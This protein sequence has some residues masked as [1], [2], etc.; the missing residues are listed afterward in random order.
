MHRA[1][2]RNPLDGSAKWVYLTDQLDGSV[3]Y[4]WSL[5]QFA[6]SK[7]D[8]SVCTLP[9]LPS[10]KKNL[11]FKYPL[12]RKFTAKATL[13][14]GAEGFGYWIMLLERTKR[15][16]TLAWKA[17]KKYRKA[18]YVPHCVCFIHVQLSLHKYVVFSV[19]ARMGNATYIIF[20]M[21]N[22][23]S[24]S[25]TWYHFQFNINCGVAVKVR[26]HQ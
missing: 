21:Q 16:S 7:I 17:I 26:S 15:F 24:G 2:K 5:S 11:F 13:W 22:S 9:Q 20:I 3:L 10:P 19:C 25:D 1:S 8:L 14:N 6:Y 4:I 23:I 12:D 18:D